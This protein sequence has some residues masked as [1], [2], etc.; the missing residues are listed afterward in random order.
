MVKKKKDSQQQTGTRPPDSPHPALKLRHT[1]RGHTSLVLGIALS[2]DG[3]SLASSSANPDNT[4]RL[5]DVRN[6]RVL[7]TLKHKAPV[8]AVCWSPDGTTVATGTSDDKR[9]YLWDSATGRQ[10]RILEGHSGTVKE[11]A[12]SPKGKIL[13][14]CSSDGTIRLWDP[15][16]GQTLHE[17]RGHLK[18][19][20]G[21]AWSPEGSRLCSGSWDNVVKLWDPES[22]KEIRTLEGHDHFV[23]S[24]AWFPNGHHIASSSFDKTVRIWDAET[25]QQQ[26]VLEGHTERVIY[27]SLLANGR[28]LAS[29]AET[30]TVI[31]WRTDTWD[32]V[33]RV[34]KIGDTGILSNLAFL[35]ALRV[36][37]A[38]G[39]LKE[40]NIWELDLALLCGAEPTTPTVF[41]VNAKAVLLGESGAGKSGLGIRIAEGVFR[42]TES[43]HGAQF[44][45][46][47]T[48]Q[49]PGLPPEVQAELTLWDLAGQPEYRIT[50]QLFLDDTDA[51]LLLFDCSDA[52][53]PFRGVPY[54]AKV[55][56]KHAPPHARKFL[57]S[58]R[59]DV[60]PV[61][62]DR[63]TINQ[64]LATYGLDQ[65]FKSS[66]Y[67]GEGVETILKHLMSEIPWDKLPRTST[68]KLFQVMREFLLERKKSGDNLVSIEEVGKAA[69]TLFT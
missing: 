34:E 50:H 43:T 69:T 53:D 20:D 1:L 55:L 22:G 13:A 12:W 19:V 59:C 36:M 26:Y 61:T 28:L 24:V 14:S 23:H 46:F 33:L 32:E 39:S 65:Y 29:L 68:P 51:A 40:V 52:N 42:Q 37:A 18:D 62:V 45:H 8:R 64:T 56:K 16:S 4:V 63:P 10:I 25:A 3:F 9:V 38:P 6:G 41:Y 2:P 49:L 66:A 67:T 11:V 31:F 5:W 21:V 48:E 17:L 30:G 60:S 27:V 58:A 57:V 44:W 35:P 15:A 47:S 54:W 7:K